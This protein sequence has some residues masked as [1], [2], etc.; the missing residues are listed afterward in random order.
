MSCCIVWRMVLKTVGE[1][2][3][4]LTAS[5]FLFMHGVRR[6]DDNL[7]S[8]HSQSE[9]KVACLEPRFSRVKD[10]FKRFFFLSSQ[11]WEFPTEEAIHC[12]LLVH[13][14]WG[15]ITKDKEICMVLTKLEK[16]YLATVYDWVVTHQDEVWTDAL[17]T[18]TN[19]DP[20]LV[21]LNQSHFGG[22][23]ISREP[24]AS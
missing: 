5:E 17:L 22:R 8:F 19:I 12:E 23:R 21:S 2:Y 16:D 10:W 1:D 3:L 4:D 15:V 11:G 7:C 18:K 20:F 13:A 9:Y 24:S 6:H 14:V